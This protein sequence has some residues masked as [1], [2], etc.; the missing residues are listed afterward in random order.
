V[1][2]LSK[3]L[4]AKFKTDDDGKL[5]S[6]R[7]DKEIRDR[8]KFIASR[9]NNG[10]RGG[11]P[12]VAKVIAKD[13]SPLLF[14]DMAKSILKGSVKDKN[15]IPPKPE[16]VKNCFMSRGLSAIDSEYETLKFLAHYTGKGWKTNGNVPVKDW[17]AAVTN[18]LIH[19]NQ[20]LKN[21]QP[22]TLTEQW[23]A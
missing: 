9:R 22:K 16:M 11:R 5:Y 20:F 19:R 2:L 15:M 12:H 4:N 13:N 21:K 3:E 7:L 1:G 18:W 6:P 23:L 10:K 14:E 8:E 17:K